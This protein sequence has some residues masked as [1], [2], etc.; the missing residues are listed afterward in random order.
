MLV[1]GQ[2]FDLF[3]LQTFLKSPLNTGIII[4]ASLSFPIKAFRINNESFLLEVF[5]WPGE[6]RPIKRPVLSD[7]IRSRWN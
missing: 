1:R 2:K 4:R 6:M 3:P 5:F 7:V